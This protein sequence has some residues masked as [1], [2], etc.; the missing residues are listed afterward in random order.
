[1]TRTE[2]ESL[3]EK[4]NVSTVHS[5]N[6]TYTYTNHCESMENLPPASYVC[7]HSDDLFRI[8]FTDDAGNR[9]FYRDVFDERIALELLFQFLL[10]LKGRDSMIGISGGV[11]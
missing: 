9:T 6:K 2:F 5:D 10:F 4:E 11:Q 3:I 1:M 8:V 7:I